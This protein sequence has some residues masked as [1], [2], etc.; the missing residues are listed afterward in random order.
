MLN[1]QKQRIKVTSASTWE[2]TEDIYQWTQSSLGWK[3]L[4]QHGKNEFFTITEVKHY[5][6]CPTK[7]FEDDKSYLTSNQ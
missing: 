1:P 3:N 2:S 5:K 7:E 4:V 6:F